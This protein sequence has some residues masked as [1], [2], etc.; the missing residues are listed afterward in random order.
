MDDDALIKELSRLSPLDWPPDEAGERIAAK[1]AAAYANQQPEPGPHQPEAGRPGAPH[2]ASRSRRPAARTVTVV[3][4]AAAAAALAIA[5][6]QVLGGSAAA[7]HP[8]AGRHTS[9]PVRTNRPTSLTAMVVVSRPGALSAVGAVPN[10]DSSLTCVTR[11]ICYIEAF[12]DHQRH[13]DIARTLNGGVTWH[14]G[15][16]LPPFNFSLWEPDISCP[17]PKVCFAPIGSR[18]LLTT[19]DAFAS[20]TV[21]PVKLPPGVTGQLKSVSCP[22]T[23]HCVAA[24]SG[25]SDEQALIFTTNGGKSWAAAKVPVMSASDEILAVQCDKHGGACIAAVSGGTGEGPTVATLGSA[26]GGASW[27]ITA[28]DPVPVSLQVFVSCGDGRDCLVGFDRGVLAFLHVTAHGQVSVRIQAFKKIWG[29]ER[30]NAVSCPTGPVCYAEAAGVASGTI[31]GATLELTRN[32]GR[33]WTSLGTPMAPALPQD[34][35]D[36]VSC[37]VPAGCVAVAYDA[38]KAQRTWVVLSNLHHGSR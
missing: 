4:T 19:T 16:T 1:V 15:A 10:G 35:S 31:D 38:T 17:K 21:R 7:P 28:D 9:G 25:P 27:A 23:E 8:R 34:V 26:D 14:G 18:R 12:R 6:W 5:G 37:P 20:V 30:V 29:R 11:S 24:V 13:V 33:T 32:D 36:F 2:P 3:A 22:T